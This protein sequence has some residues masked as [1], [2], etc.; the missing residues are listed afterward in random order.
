MSP[1]IFKPPF[2]FK[3]DVWSVGVITYFMLTGFL[4]FFGGTVAEVK[5]NVL[6]RKIQWP[7][8][9][10]GSSRS[11]MIED[12]IKELV[13]K[14]LEKDDRLRPNA[15]DA[16]AHDWLSRPRGDRSCT[17]FSSAVALN[18]YSFSKLSWWKRCVLNFIAHIWDFNV[19]ANIRSVFMEMDFQ[20]KG[21]ITLP[22]IAYA[23]ESAGFTTTDA[24]RCAKSIDLSHSGCVTFTALSA[25]CVFPLV[26]LDR[27]IL[28]TTFRAFSP[29]RKGRIS[30]D[31]IYEL[32]LGSRSC[33]KD[34]VDGSKMDYRNQLIEELKQIACDWMQ[35]NPS[36]SSSMLSHSKPYSTHATESGGLDIDFALFEKWIFTNT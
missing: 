20:N 35:L 17:Q 16:L 32:I 21:H 7:R 12:S 27:R 11:L 9:Y 29:N 26:P 24:W 1:E 2:G 18:I 6:Y 10:S 28:K 15:R 23:M 14:L 4:P 31:N 22:D 13:E 3:A 19:S 36:K 34:K 5:S 8:E 30:S 33:I 25:A